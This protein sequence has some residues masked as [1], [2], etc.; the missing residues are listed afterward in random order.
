M[1]EEY[2]AV[3][4]LLACVSEKEGWVFGEREGKRRVVRLGEVRREYQDLVSL[5][6]LFSWVER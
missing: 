4:N 1:K 5:L 2:L 3:M 6:S